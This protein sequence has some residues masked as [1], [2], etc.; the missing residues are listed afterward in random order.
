MGSLSTASRFTNSNWS[1]L[2]PETREFHTRAATRPQPAT[3]AA[4]PQLPS[5]PTEVPVPAPTAAPVPDRLVPVAFPTSAPVPA[6]ACSGCTGTCIELSIKTDEQP[7]Q[8]RWLLWDR[9]NR[10]W[11]KTVKYGKYKTANKRYKHK[12]C[13]PNTAFTLKVQDRSSDGLAGKGYYSLVVDG[14]TIVDRKS[15]FGSADKVFF[16]GSS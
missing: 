15:N 14:E 12:L 9:S 2:A 4:A 6:G 8:I 7:K 1:C 10:E 13:Y 16:K 5:V 3:G 11:L